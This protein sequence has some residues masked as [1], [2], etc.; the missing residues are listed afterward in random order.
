[1]PWKEIAVL[2]ALLLCFI[3]IRQLGKRRGDESRSA[4]LMKKYA[5]LTPVLLKETEEEELVEAVVS[6]VLAKTTATRRPDPVVT[7][8]G[9][10]QPFTV[11]YSVWAVCKEMANGSFSSLM[12]TATR[13]VLEAAEEALPVIGAAE[14]AGAL[15]TLHQAHK[16][17]A[18]TDEMEQIFHRA[19]ERECPLALC[20]AYVRDHI[21]QLTGTDTEETT[22]EA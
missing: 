14:T 15:T 12:H 3:A 10:P 9:L 2:V 18:V 20:A 19:V 13:E 4:R 5:E 1:M 6:H 17:K 11:I 16:D 22:N 7:L 21:P 8:A